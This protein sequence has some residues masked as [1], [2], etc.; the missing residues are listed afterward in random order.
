MAFALW[1]DPRPQSPLPQVNIELPE[2]T[3]PILKATVEV[4]AI[5]SEDV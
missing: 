1:R 5:S 4:A 3:V 2:E